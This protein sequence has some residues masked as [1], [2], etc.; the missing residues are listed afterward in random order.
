MF[1]L[2]GKVALVTGAARGIGSGIAIGLAQ[3]GA[4]IAINDLYADGDA[5]GLAAQIRGLGRRAIVLAADVSREAQVRA[6]FEG[7]DAAFGRL[8]ILVNNAG[9]SRP[10]TIMETSLASWNELLG[11]NLTGSFLCA[12]LAMERMTRQRFGRILQIA[13]V[14]AHQ[15]AL[16]GHAHYAASKSGQLGL[17][18]TLARTAAAY[19]ITVNAIAPGV[20]ETKLLRRTLGDARIQAL[21][22][23]I[24][25]GLGRLEDIA[26][27][28]VF[29]ASDEARYVTGF[30]LDVNGGQYLR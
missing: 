25:L 3:A 21:G 27:A 8:D 18:K 6:M 1:D 10:E 16:Y 4:D 22:Q 29:L 19:G 23:E 9:L 12:K 20:I 26:A 2:T 7:L 5:K 15:G 30:T 13:S 28:A 11:V 24:P 17:T 14:V